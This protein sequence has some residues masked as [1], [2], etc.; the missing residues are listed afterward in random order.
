MSD[1]LEIRN[2]EV[3]GITMLSLEGYV[4]LQTAQ[5]LEAKI[6]KLI[7]SKKYRIVIDCAGL[8]FISSAGIGV[9]M[10]YVDEVRQHQGDIVFCRVLQDRIRETFDLVKFGE[11]F[12]VV[13]DDAEAR[14]KFSEGPK[15]AR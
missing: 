8:T 1:K 4:D 5:Y 7:R 9:F 11:F 10:G 6:Q 14:L 3:Q 12:H 15:I 2:I 13:A